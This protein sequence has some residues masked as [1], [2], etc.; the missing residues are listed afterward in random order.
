MSDTVQLH[1]LRQALE[2]AGDPN[3]L[4]RRIGISGRQLFRMLDGDPIPSW[5][6]LRAADFINEVQAQLEQAPFDPDRHPGNRTT[7]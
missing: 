6:F 2:L 3:A 7:Q 5:V 4:A 1:T